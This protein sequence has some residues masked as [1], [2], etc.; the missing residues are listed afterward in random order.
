M[1]ITKDSKGTAYI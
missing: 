1:H